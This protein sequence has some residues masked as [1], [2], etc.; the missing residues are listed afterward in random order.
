MGS[1]GG[2]PSWP[3][4]RGSRSLRWP[5]DLRPRSARW[6]PAA[7]CRAP[8]PLGADCL[9]AFLWIEAR[10][11]RPM[12]PLALF[13]SRQF[14]GANAV[15]LAVYFALG[16]STFLLIIHLQSV[17]GYSPL[18]AGAALT[19][20]TLL[21]LV[22][23]PV[24]GKVPSRLGDRAPLTGRP[25]IAAARRGPLARVRPGPGLPPYRPPGRPRPGR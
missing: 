3:A 24:A 7:R 4:W 25:L 14:S 12:L 15:T 19:P 11:A 13:R 8:A 16:G 9:A 5:A 18:A 1:G 2:R 21:L 23:S 6:S 22:L 17:L 20:A 10:S